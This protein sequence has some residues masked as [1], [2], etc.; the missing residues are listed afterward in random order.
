MERDESFRLEDEGWAAL[1]AAVDRIPAE[2]RDERGVV[3]DWSVKDLIW[4]C[5]KW[6]DWVR[7]PLRRI[8][9][10]SYD[11]RGE[12]PWEQLNDRWAADS[13]ALSWDEVERGVADM[14]RDARAALAALP[15]IG[16]DAIRE[17]NSETF[18]HYA[19]HTA[20]IERFAQES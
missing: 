11:P 4:H 8:E 5:G 3:P 7:E 9:D 12:Y 14:R 1:M 2:R 18:E 16:E 15:T 17:F 10:G 13:K 6:A 19:E 20:E